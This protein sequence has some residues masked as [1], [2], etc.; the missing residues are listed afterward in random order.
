[1]I[2]KTLLK[3]INGIESIILFGSRARNEALSESDYDLMVI[4]PFQGTIFERL[5]QIYTYIPPELRIE[6]LG[7]TAE[8]FEEMLHSFHLLALEIL[9]DGIPLY[10]SGIFEKLHKEFKQLQSK[11]LEKKEFYWVYPNQ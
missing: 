6:A 9:N 10:D 8:E 2:T 4:A 7:W 11:G 3:Q 1:M 5:K